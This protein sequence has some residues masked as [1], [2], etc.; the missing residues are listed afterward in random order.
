MFYD[1]FLK[2]DA[3]ERVLRYNGKLIRSVSSIWMLKSC[4][5]KLLA[6]PVALIALFVLFQWATQ[7]NSCGESNPNL[8]Y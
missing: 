5:R 7:S 1:C 8:R 4:R 3:W 2:R 6:A